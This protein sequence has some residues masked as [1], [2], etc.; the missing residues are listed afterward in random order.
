MPKA[1]II[2]LAED[3]HQMRT[4]PAEG[5]HGAHTLPA[6]FRDEAVKLPA[7]PRRFARVSRLKLP[8]L[9]Q[10]YQRARKADSTVRA[11]RGDAKV[12]EAWCHG[13]GFRSLPASAEAVAAFLVHEAK[14]GGLPPPSAGGWPRSA[15]RTAGRRR[16]TLRTMRKSVRS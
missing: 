11:Y 7:E 16:L 5:V 9:V 3:T 6:G 8:P 10:A 15:T 12:F 2:L 4:L 13:Y 1:L 14:P